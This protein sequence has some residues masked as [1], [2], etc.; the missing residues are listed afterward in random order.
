MRRRLDLAGLVMGVAILVLAPPPRTEGAPPPK[1]ICPTACDCQGSEIFHPPVTAAAVLRCVVQGKAVRL[2]RVQVVGGPLDFSSLPATALR[3]APPPGIP[4]AGDPRTGLF[5]ESLERELGRA[6]PGAR[7]VR[8]PFRI[9]N[10]TIVEGMTDMLPPAERAAP[11][12]PVAF[13]QAVDLE[14]T[15]IVGPV[16]LPRARFRLSLNAINTIFEHSLDL[17]GARFADKVSFSNATLYGHTSFADG[18]FEGQ[19]IFSGIEV[20]APDGRL[21]FP[22]SRFLRGVTF[23]QDARPSRLRD[24]SFVEAQIGGADAEFQDVT[25]AGSAKFTKA[26]FGGDARFGG[27]YFLNLAQFEATTFKGE[28]GFAG[29]TIFAAGA[30]FTGARFEGRSAA[31]FDGARFLESAT[32]VGARFTGTATFTGGSF[33]RADFRDAE[34][35]GATTFAGR[36]FESAEFGSERTTTAFG[37]QAVFDFARFRRANFENVQFRGRTSFASAQFGVGDVC[38]GYPV[39]ANFGGTSFSDIVEFGGSVFHGQV[40]LSYTSL[41]PSKLYL[42]WR[43]IE[44]R[45]ISQVLRL[46]PGPCNESREF[47]VDSRDAMPRSELLRWLERAF[48]SR[49][50]IR[51]A[52]AVYYDLQAEEAWETIRSPRERLTER[53]QALATV[54]FFGIPAGYGVRPLRVLGALLVILVMGWVFYLVFARSWLRADREWTVERKLG[55]LPW[56]PNESAAS[57]GNAVELACWVSIAALSSYQVRGAHVIVPPGGRRWLWFVLATQRLCGYL[58]LGYLL[59]ALSTTFPLLGKLF[60]GAF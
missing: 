24:T 37:R 46:M 43:Q 49:D 1:P 26:H 30:D 42:R 44:G 20:P 14:G 33:T 13:L 60:S 58:L 8:E 31:S 59:Y 35:E 4:G 23:K 5:L 57:S 41:D 18:T 29:T 47:I 32:F 45:A 12:S 2:D 16:R 28:G 17:G 36:E 21:D 9:T 11:F 51:D 25:F 19:A 48:R 55:S 3:S 38:S 7:L 15:Y 53:V 27:A 6:A 10:S 52:N 22:R 39:A 50:L 56:R 54:A 40:N 34:F